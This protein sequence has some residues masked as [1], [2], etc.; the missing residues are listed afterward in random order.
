[1]RLP[2]IDIY[3]SVDIADS[4]FTDVVGVS[5]DR[6]RESE[7]CCGKEGGEENGRNE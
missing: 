5:S 7:C 3:R 2:Q 6:W 4:Y 1:M